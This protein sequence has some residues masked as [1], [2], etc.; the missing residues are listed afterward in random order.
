V[1]TTDADEGVEVTHPKH[2]RGVITDY[3]PKFGG[4]P[5]EITVRFYETE[6]EQTLPIFAV[7]LAATVATTSIDKGSYG[8]SATVDDGHCTVEIT[9]DGTGGGYTVELSVDGHRVDSATLSW[10]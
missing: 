9:P 7:E 3:D 2:G 1:K 6:A 4:E 10:Q 8:F 5:D